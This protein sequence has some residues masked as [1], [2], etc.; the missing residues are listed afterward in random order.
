MSKL[1][2][3]KKPI[4][5]IFCAAIFIAGLLDIKYKGLF[6]RLLPGSVQIYLDDQFN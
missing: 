1:N 4:L 6:Y 2:K 5:L 3:N